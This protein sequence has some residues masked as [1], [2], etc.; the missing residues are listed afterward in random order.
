MPVLAQDQ[1]EGRGIVPDQTRE[2]SEERLKELLESG[3]YDYA[4]EEADPPS[5]LRRAID[6]LGSGINKFF[7][8]AARTP[9]GQVLLYGSGFFL[10]LVAIIKL[11]GLKGRDVF[12]RNSKNISND[13]DY[14][15]ENIHTVDFEKLLKEA[16]AKNDFK[17]A[18]RVTYLRTL[19]LL[20]DRMVVEWEAGKTNYEYLYE[21]DQPTLREPFR[22]ISYHF[23]YAWY[24]DF[25][26]NEQNYQLAEEQAQII[27]AT[28]VKVATEA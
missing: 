14:L 3:D 13:F 23:D 7:S 22:T 12:Y 5:F 1:S 11:F 16:L 19:K 17:L 20:S 2:Y 8:A 10:L 6:Y 15:E 21:I 28:A 9:L 24:G 27:D 4:R 26:V 18:I 25:E